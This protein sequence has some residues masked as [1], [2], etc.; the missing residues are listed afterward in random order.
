[1][2]IF[3]PCKKCLV[4]MVCQNDCE[5]FN[6]YEKQFKIGLHILVI[7]PSILISIGTIFIIFYISKLLLILIVG[8]IYFI[9]LIILV[10]ISDELST[11]HLMDC[12]C[13]IAIFIL[14]PLLLI[15]FSFI[16]II[17]DYDI[18][19][20]LIYKYTPQKWKEK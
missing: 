15:T 13:L 2:S 14:I 8:F 4:N 6:L 20:K 1:M 12:I 19:N 17:D 10:L 18:I 5:N 16:L 9:E 3:N 11:A 7:I